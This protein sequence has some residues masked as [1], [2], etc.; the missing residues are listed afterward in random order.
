LGRQPSGACVVGNE[1][2]VKLAADGYGHGLCL[3]EMLARRISRAGKLV[4]EYT[5]IL[6]LGLVG[7]ER[8]AE[9]PGVAISDDDTV[10]AGQHLAGVDRLG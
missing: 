10:V 7:E 9:E 4:A 8:V 2:A 3:A 5:D 6:V 1:E